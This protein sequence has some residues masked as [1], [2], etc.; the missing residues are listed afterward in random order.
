[1]DR[2]SRSNDILDFGKLLMGLLASVAVLLICITH[3]IKPLH[4]QTRQTTLTL[5]SLQQKEA[6]MDA[7][8]AAREDLLRKVQT[9]ED[10]KLEESLRVLYKMVAPD[11]TV[12]ELRREFP[13]PMPVDLPPAFNE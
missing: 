9:N 3:W 6:R 7:L 1:M 4:E 13:R 11:E 8:I 10:Q 2:N 12:L 5:Q